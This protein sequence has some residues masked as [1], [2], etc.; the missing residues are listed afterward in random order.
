[1]AGDYIETTGAYLVSSRALESTSF[2]FA[3]SLPSA[4]ITDSGGGVETLSTWVGTSA[5]VGSASS[6]S[7]AEVAFVVSTVVLTLES[8]STVEVLLDDGPRGEPQIGERGP[9]R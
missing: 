3:K 2:S 7:L 9:P 1:V 5:K 4:A 6:F 8:F